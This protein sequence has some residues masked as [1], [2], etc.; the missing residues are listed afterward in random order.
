M[1][2]KPQ[3][4]LPLQASSRWEIRALWSLAENQEPH[5]TCIGKRPSAHMELVS[6]MWQGA[7]CS[8][9]P[10]P[11]SSICPIRMSSPPSRNCF[12]QSVPLLVE[13]VSHEETLPASR[14]WSSA[15]YSQFPESSCPGF[16]PWLLLLTLILPPA[17]E[18][19]WDD[20]LD[21][22]GSFKKYF[23]C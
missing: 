21:E 3:H 5:R 13:G 16:L 8:K 20:P 22:Y 7:P 18:P 17:P 10:E 15:S 19:C 11:F 12:S 6:F 1:K 14:D 23:T 2:W 4:S 9:P